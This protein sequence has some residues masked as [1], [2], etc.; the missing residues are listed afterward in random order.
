MAFAIMVSLL[1]SFTLT[2]MLSARWLK[3]KKHGN[4]EHTT[5]RTRRS[6][7]PSTC[8][9]RACSSGRWRTAPSSPALAVLVLLS[10][11]AAVHDRQQELPA[12]ATTS[13]S[14]RSTCARPRAPASSRPRC[15]PT[16]SPTRSAQQLPEVDYTLVTIAG[17]PAQTRNLGT[18]YVR[19][20]P[21][22]A[23]KRDQFAVMDV[24]RK[25]HPAAVLRRPP[26]LGAAG[27]GHR[28]RRLAERRRSSSRSTARICGKLESRSASSWSTQV[29]AIPGVVDVDTSL[30]VGKPELSVQ[31]RSAEGGRP[32]RPDRR[33]RRG[34]AAAGRRRSGDDLQRGRRAVRGAPARP[35]RRT[36]RPRRRSRR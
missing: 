7:T 5:R 10:Q 13:R 8:S 1:V 17:D 11:R 18:I 28:R 34:A 6:S 15:S 21:L 3:V 29:K 35:G 30:N 14:S 26:H 31:R 19:L 24:V 23:R 36:A 20:K 12:A 16:A 22:E 2:P 4:D 27:R 25:R 32:R 9:T 33:R